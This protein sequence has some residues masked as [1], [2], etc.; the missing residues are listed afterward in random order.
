MSEIYIGTSGWKKPQWRGAFYPRGLPQA[1]ELEFA[2]QRLS[3]LEIN[4]TF[5][6]PQ[7]PVTFR[8]WH[9]ETPSGFVFSV[10]ALGLAT[11]SPH[12][13]NSAKHIDDFVASGVYELKNKLGA[14]LWQF[15]PELEFQATEVDTFVSLLPTDA[16]NAIEVRNESFA[17]PEFAAIARTHNI[18]IVFTN[19]PGYPTIRELTA[20]FAYARLSSTDD[21]N[22]NGYDAAALDQWASDI[23]SWKRDAFIYFNNPA[24][25]LTHTPFNA[26]RLIERVGRP[27]SSD[28]ESALF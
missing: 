24:G 16:R 9:D 21:R 4:A 15:P 13:R 18:A 25:E 27:A 3:S 6:G 20:D 1:R 2:S 7:S 5:Y 22:E 28:D 8:R 23:T 11:R 14:I 17:H 26:L 10:K 12:L 19:D